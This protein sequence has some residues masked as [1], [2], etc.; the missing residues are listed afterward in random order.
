MLPKHGVIS[1]PANSYPKE[2]R[3]IISALLEL[4]HAH[5]RAPN[6]A[7]QAHLPSSDYFKP[8]AF[9]ATVFEESDVIVLLCTTVT[10]VKRIAW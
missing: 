5:L 1:I 10:R 3:E 9:R 8:V 6:Q 2:L 4:D 7:S